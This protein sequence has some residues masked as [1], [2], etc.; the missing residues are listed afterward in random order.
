[1]SDND[2]PNIMIVMTDDVLETK[3]YTDKDEGRL[4]NFPYTNSGTVQTLH[5]LKFNKFHTLL[6]STESTFGECLRHDSKF[7]I[8]QSNKHVF[9]NNFEAMDP[10]ASEQEIDDKDAV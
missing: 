4:Y 3:E 2:Y 1:M 9:T 6:V 10:N 7:A 8:M 5:S